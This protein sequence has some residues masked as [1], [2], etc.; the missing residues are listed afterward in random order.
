MRAQSD[1]RPETIQDIGNGNYYVNMDIHEV[2]N[3]MPSGDG[4]TQ[5]HVTYEYE[6]VRIIGYPTYGATVEALIR[7]RYTESDELAIQRQRDT[8]PEK[9]T[10]YDNFCEECKA[11]A[12]PVFF[13]EEQVT[14]QAEE[15]TE[16]TG[17]SEEEPS[18]V[19]PE[20]NTLGNA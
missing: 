18:V 14:E 7:E 20:E 13:P 10:E 17:E 16:A 12:R 15:S 5:T 3:E 2:R 1:N 11:K 6:S 4:E 9:F 19:I 8:K